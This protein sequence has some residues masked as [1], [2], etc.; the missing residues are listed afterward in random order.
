M[1]RAL[2]MNI[3]RELAA[4]IAAAGLLPEP[5]RTAARTELWQVQRLS[6]AGQAAA[7][8][9]WHEAMKSRPATA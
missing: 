4:I 1:R 6:P 9:R 3:T 7:V 5:T 2:P 8:T